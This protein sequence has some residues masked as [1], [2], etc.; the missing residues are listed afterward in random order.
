MN[1]IRQQLTPVGV[2]SEEQT[3]AKELSSKEIKG[4]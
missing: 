4:A 2:L 3:A 1:I